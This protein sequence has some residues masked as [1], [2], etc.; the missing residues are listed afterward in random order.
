MI[1]RYQVQ[2]EVCYGWLQE[3]EIAKLQGDIYGEYARGEART[4]LSRVKLLSPVQPSKI[5]CVGLNYVDHAK[6]VNLDLPKEPLL[7]LKPSTTVVG[8]GDPVIYPAQSK[9]LDYEAEL[10]VVIKKKA[11]RIRE[12]EAAD[13]ILGYTCANDIT[14]RDIQF[15]DGQWTRGKSFDTFC[16]IGPGIVP[17]I[18]PSGLEI[19]LTVNGEV[20][21][22]S[23]TKNL[24]FS[25][26]Y[27]VHY[28][29]Q[30]MTLLPG[31]VIITGTP[32][33]IGPMQIGDEVS[34]YIEGIGELNN[35]IA[36]DER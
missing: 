9:R 18:D 8:P 28:I 19:K 26:P 6:E 20:K 5:V 32:A 35:D 29:S 14:A 11:Y 27:L 1:V 10:G 13:Y 15:A 23:N 16:P 24:I 17:G 31:D 33:G 4:P 22:S 7:F 21:Q 36:G 12:N 3:G 25:V 2:D 34:V 30:V